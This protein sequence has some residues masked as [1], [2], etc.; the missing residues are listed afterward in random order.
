MKD[1]AKNYEEAL[2]LYKHALDYFMHAI[3]CKCHNYFHFIMCH[4][5]MMEF[6]SFFNR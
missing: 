2:R 6:V 4:L 1:K 3:K 5:L